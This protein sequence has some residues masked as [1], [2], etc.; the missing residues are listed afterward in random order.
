MLDVVT[1]L[2]SQ[3]KY[4]LRGKTYMRRRK[5]LPYTLF[6]N[7]FIS[8]NVVESKQKNIIIIIYVIIKYNNI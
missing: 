5:E 1:Q 2:V 4:F 7:Y 8:E 6:F 3:E